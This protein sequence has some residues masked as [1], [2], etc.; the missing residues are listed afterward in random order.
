MISK[1][2]ILLALV[3]LLM[4]S[5]ML[6]GMI[7][8]PSG[9]EPSMPYMEKDEDVFL[10]TI[11]GRDWHTLESLAKEK[12]T[13][14]EY[15]GPGTLTFTAILPDDKPVYLSYGWCASDE[16]TLQQNFEHIS[17]GLYFEEEQL[18]EDVIHITT[19]STADGMTCVAFG[20]LMSDWEPGEY[21]LKAVATFDEEI[22]DGF[23]DFDAGDYVFEY[24]VTVRK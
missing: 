22:N 24:N 18:G 16:T 3:P 10:E 8:L 4:I 12:Y 11:N 5:C 1:K 15:A 6:P 2:P 13:E 14:E 17:I 23:A 20:V 19:F 21:R 7:P 9:D